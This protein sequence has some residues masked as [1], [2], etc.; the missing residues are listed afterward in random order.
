MNTKELFLKCCRAHQWDPLH[1]RKDGIEPID[2]TIIDEEARQALIQGKPELCLDLIKLAKTMN[3]QSASQLE[4]KAAAV[5][6]S[7]R[8]ESKI[9]HKKNSMKDPLGELVKKLLHNC[10][11]KDWSAK[12]LQTATLTNNRWDVEKV[13]LKEAEAARHA[14]RVDVSLDLINTTLEAGFNSLWLHHL[15]ARALQTAGKLEDAIGIWEKLAIQEIEGFSEKVHLSLKLAKIEKTISHAQQ[16]EASGQLDSAIEILAFA[17]L[18]NP[19]H[20]DLETILKHMLRKR[21][22]QN[23]QG[24]K[25]SRLEGH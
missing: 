4:L 15:K 13:I 3:L 20:N 21:R 23:N 12:F 9:N 19:D 8:K 18:N 1:I 22:H 17:L 14:D 10:Q 16:Q 24:T 2:S 6:Q 25:A 5:K 11:E 7:E